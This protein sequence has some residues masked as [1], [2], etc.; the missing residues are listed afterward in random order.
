MTAITRSEIEA[1][2]RRWFLAE[3]LSGT[4]VDALHRAWQQ[5]EGEPL[6]MNMLRRQFDPANQVAEGRAWW[7]ERQNGAHGIVLPITSIDMINMWL[8]YDPPPGAPRPRPWCPN[9]LVG[10]WR[11]SA[12]GKSRDTL[13]PPP[14][15]REW[16]LHPDGRL[17]TVGD[18]RHQGWTWCAHRGGVFSL[19]LYAPGHGLP[20]I[21]SILNIDGGEMRIYAADEKLGFMRW[22]RGS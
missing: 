13:D 9:V 2:V 15:P 1:Q 6:Y 3:K 22:Q 20:D 17:D 18:Q 4:E 21:W 8:T 5:H 16:V 12:A 19:W 10:R 14:S 11:L 7:E